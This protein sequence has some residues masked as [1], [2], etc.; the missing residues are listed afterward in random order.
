MDNQIANKD[1]CSTETLSIKP[2]L[3]KG[4]TLDYAVA[5]CIGYKIYSM[6]DNWPGNSAISSESS[7]SPVIIQNLTNELWL[8]FQGKSVPFKP[9]ETFDQCKV[10]LD[11]CPYCWFQRAGKIWFAWFKSQSLTRCIGETPEEAIS[12]AFV[13]Y[14][15]GETITIPVC[16]A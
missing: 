3:L 6:E 16:F 7:E 9:S 13:K 4:R 15:L 5:L 1:S 14:K 11:S 12:R 8:E 10:L 2:E